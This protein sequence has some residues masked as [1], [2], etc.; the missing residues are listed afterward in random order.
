MKIKKKEEVANEDKSEI[1]I[2]FDIYL[3]EENREP[4]LL[5]TKKTLFFRS[6][7]I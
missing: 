3:C 2:E 4:N 5:S 6:V 7:L 1:L